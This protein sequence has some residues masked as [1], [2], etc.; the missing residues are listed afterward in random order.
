MAS[1][2]LSEMQS[3]AEKMLPP[4]RGALVLVLVEIQDES[5]RFHQ[6]GESGAHAASGIACVSRELAERK[7][8]FRKAESSYLEAHSK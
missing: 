1:P 4:G 2:F 5:F 7:A 6:Q 8:R 3:K